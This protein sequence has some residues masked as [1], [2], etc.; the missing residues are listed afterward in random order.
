[1]ARNTP[2]QG[3]AAD[4]LKMAMIRVEERLEREFPTARMLLTVHDELVLEARESEAEA[5]GAMVKD[6]M[7]LVHP[8]AVPLVVD[9]G[10]GANWAEC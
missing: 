5:V 1:M 8:L 6:T 2:I 10:I 7:E 9:V 3:T 4:L